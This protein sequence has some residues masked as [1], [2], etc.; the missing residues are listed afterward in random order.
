[1]KMEMTLSPRLPVAANLT[2]GEL[3]QNPPDE[4][5]FYIHREPP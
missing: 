2:F 5:L 1:M 4:L 3:F